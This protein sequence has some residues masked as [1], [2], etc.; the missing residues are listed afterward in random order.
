MVNLLPLTEGETITAIL[1][2]PED[3]VKRVAE[4][5]VEHFL[6][7]ATASGTVRRN[8]MSDFDS[9]RANGKIAM[10]LEEGQKL[11]GVAI[12][13]D[14]SDILLSS[15]NGKCIR[16]GLKEVPITL[17][18][19]SGVI[20]IKLDDFIIIGENEYFSFYEE[21]LLLECYEEQLRK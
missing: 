17:R 2:V 11:V 5:G 14:N 1:P 21:K 20:G 8:R 10:K 6:M 15:K 16:F 18:V 12:C 3:E 13:D 9:I 7:F 19:S 4:S